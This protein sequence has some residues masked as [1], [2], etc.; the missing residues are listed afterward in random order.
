M[1]SC[2]IRRSGVYRKTRRGAGRGE[3][4][5]VGT[6]IFEIGHLN[7]SLEIVTP[8]DHVVLAVDPSV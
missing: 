3:M 5:G 6:C 1:A 7:K 4:Q 8:P 2:Y